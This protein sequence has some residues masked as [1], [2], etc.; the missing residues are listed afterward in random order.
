[1]AGALRNND[2]MPQKL[3]REEFKMTPISKLALVALTSLAWAADRY[4]PEQLNARFYYDLGLDSIDVSAYPE[5]QQAEYAVFQRNCAQCH[6]LARPINSPYIEEKD[7]TR[8]VTRMH[9][10]SKE[11]GKMEISAG[12]AAQIVDFLVYDAQIRKVQ[13]SD[14]FNAKTE[15]LKAMYAQ[16]LAKRSDS[17]I[18]QDRKNAVPPAPYTGAGAP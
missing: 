17:Q 9:E 14:E 16:V 18:E 7:W 6:T 10:M 12:D 11:G 8:F 3:E 4:T 2:Q 1:M 5:K 13:F 15:D